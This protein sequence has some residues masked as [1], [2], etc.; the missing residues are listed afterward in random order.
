MSGE[1]L[2]SSASTKVTMGESEEEDV[3]RMTPKDWE[4]I[5]VVRKK[6]QQ[7]SCESYRS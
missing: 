7:N 5:Y 6:D 3:E 2:S 4:S 1:L